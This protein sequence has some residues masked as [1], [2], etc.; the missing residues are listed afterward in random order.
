MNSTKN[1]NK[2]DIPKTGRGRAM[3][4]IDHYLNGKPSQRDFDDPH[5]TLKSLYKNSQV[6]NTF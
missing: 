5:L 6:K 1:T 4:M 3:L 2:K